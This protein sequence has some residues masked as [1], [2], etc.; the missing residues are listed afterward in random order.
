MLVAVETVFFQCK[1]I[2]RHQILTTGN[3]EETLETQG[4]SCYHH[5]NDNL[6]NDS[7]GSEIRIK[8]IWLN[9]YENMIDSL[10]WKIFL[11]ALMT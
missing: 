3:A 5:P 1:T 9:M 6:D 2:S 4:Q 7:V 8:L 11:F 10:I